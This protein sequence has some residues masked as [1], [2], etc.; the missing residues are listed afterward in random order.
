MK[1]TRWLVADF[2]TTSYETYKQ[3]GRTWVWLYAI[4]D[5]EGNII[6]HGT[7]IKSFIKFTRKCYGQTIYFHNLKFDGSFI[8]SYLLESGAVYD[9][10][11]SSSGLCFRTLIGEMGEFYSIDLKFT[12][13]KIVHF[14]DSLKLLPFKAEKIAKDFDLPVRKGKI[15]YSN[16]EVTPEVLDYVFNDVK[17]IALALSQIKSEG[18]LRMTTA[19]CA[20]DN[21]VKRRKTQYMRMVFPSLD[22]SFLTTW[23]QA[24]RGGRSQVSPLYSNKVLHSVNRFDINSMY[25]HIMRNLPLP[26]GE[27]ILINGPSKY[28]FELYHIRIGFVLKPGHLP[29]LLRKGSIFSTG[30]TYYISTNDIEEMYISNID[31][32]LVKRNYDVYFLEYLPDCYG[33]YTSNI[34][35]TDYVDY[36]YSKKLIDKG[37]KKIVDKLMLNSLYGKFGSNVM[38]QTK[39]PSLNENLEIQYTLTDETESKHY[40]LPI[41]IAI[42]SHAHKLIDDAIHETGLSNFV[43]CD[44]DSVHTLGTLPDS[45]I[46][47]TDLGKFKHEAIEETAKYVRQKCYITKED[48]DYHI[49]CA[50]MTQNIKDNYIKD[51][52][53]RDIFD[54][55]KTGLKMTGKLLPKRVKGGTVLYETTFEI[56]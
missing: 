32:T 13:G 15:D 3:E 20:Y 1:S 31:L 45:W 22:T 23:R 30:D 51:T 50:G 5:P 36:W 19:S 8:I 12:R 27:P 46:H 41:A 10:N 17:I 14:H 2:E 55:F 24:Y 49:T 7:N 47:A 48:G 28:R 56:K 33:F 9:E 53:E 52:P 42:V 4:S 44:T 16:Y 29:S 25:P 26:Y 21:F 38:R 43:Y 37:A 54:N 35:F 6:N 39:I 18:M 34:L 11:L 40:Y